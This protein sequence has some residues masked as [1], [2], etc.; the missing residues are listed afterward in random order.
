MTTKLQGLHAVWN[1][2]YFDLQKEQIAF[3]KSFASIFTCTFAYDRQ[4]TERAAKL[5]AAAPDML[6]AVQPLADLVEHFTGLDDDTIAVTAGE[7]RAIRE[8]V[9]IAKEGRL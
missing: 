9:R 6:E 4:E 7:L 3:G 8:A 2:H 5:F 1:G